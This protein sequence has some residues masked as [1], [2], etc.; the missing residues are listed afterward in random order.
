[1]PHILTV[2]ACDE[3]LK[4]NLLIQLIIYFVARNLPYR[5]VVL[6][7]KILDLHIGQLEVVKVN[8]TSEYKR[9]LVKLVVDHGCA[10]LLH[11]LQLGEHSLLDTTIDEQVEVASGEQ[12]LEVGV[13]VCRVFLRL[14][15]FF[16]V[17]KR[18]L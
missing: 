15:D 9:Q 14:F 3:V 11:V 18:F 4:Q 16:I 5:Q 8:L 7:S 13:G 6:A 1:M 2:H 12:E 10:Y 17:I